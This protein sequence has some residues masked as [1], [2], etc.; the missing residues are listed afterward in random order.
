MTNIICRVSILFLIILSVWTGYVYFKEGF[1][2]DINAEKKLG[3]GLIRGTAIY[4]NKTDK[5]DKG[6]LTKEKF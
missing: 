3:K 6:F 2:E 4:F 1:E 5:L